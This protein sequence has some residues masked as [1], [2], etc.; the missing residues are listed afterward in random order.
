MILFFKL[1]KL[2]IIFNLGRIK[3]V[4][5]QIEC[6]P[7][8][9]QFSLKS[10]CKLNGIDITAYS[11]LG[12]PGLQ[13]AKGESIL[14]EEPIIVEIAKR[15]GKTPAQVLLK[16]QNQRGNVTI[17]KSVTLARI[18]ENF[19]SFDFELR[20]EEMKAIMAMNKNKRI[21]VELR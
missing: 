9:D 12:N 1:F 11:P 8:L 17:A 18:E 6:H 13:R 20:D 2:K 14:L 4:M 10:F 15:H 19:N 21:C 3:P 7:H 5:N 16:F